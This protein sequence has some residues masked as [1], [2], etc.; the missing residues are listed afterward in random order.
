MTMKLTLTLVGNPS[1]E[2]ILAAVNSLH[3]AY[4]EF[5]VNSAVV[6]EDHVEYHDLANKAFDALIEQYGP[7]GFDPVGRLNEELTKKGKPTV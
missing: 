4:R 7:S 3:W 5:G 1:N 2:R 6:H